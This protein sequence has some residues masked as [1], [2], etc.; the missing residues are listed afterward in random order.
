MTL[1]KARDL[2]V[3]QKVKTKSGEEYEVCGLSEFISALSRNTTIYVRCK[4]ENGGIIKFSHKE[5]VEV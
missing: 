4:T 5:L 1:K 3:G 2:R